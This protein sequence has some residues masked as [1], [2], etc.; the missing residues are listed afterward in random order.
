MRRAFV[1]I[2]RRDLKIA[3]RRVS[4]LANPLLFFLIVASLFPLAVSPDE[5]HLRGIGS[6][7][8][9]VVALLSALL[10]LEGLF[11]TDAEDGSLEQ[12]MLS[13]VPLG[14]A[15]LAK[16]AAHWLVTIVPLVLLTPLLALS[17]YLPVAV[18]PVMVF[19]LL[20]ATPTLSVL[21]ALGAALTLGLR[22]GGAIVGLLVLP[23]TAPLLI[24]GTRAIELG[25][26]GEPTAAPLYLLAAL[27]VLSVSLGPVAIAAALRVGVE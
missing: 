9:W 24:F 7:V 25:M 3:F 26:F 2:L 17:F 5:E 18:L 13:P 22:R 1:A 6:G 11:R 23:L 15:V 19:A 20:L 8:L 16:V 12:L 21:V 10:A 14:V 27:A 4:E